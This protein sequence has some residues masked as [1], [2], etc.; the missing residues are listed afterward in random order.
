MTT[1]IT[2]VRQDDGSDVAA[3]GPDLSALAEQLVSA[4]RPAGC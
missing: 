1:K 4:A 3:A 2:D